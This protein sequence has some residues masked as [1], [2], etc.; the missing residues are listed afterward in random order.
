MALTALFEK[1]ERHPEETGSVYTLAENLFPRGGGRSLL[2]EALLK[3]MSSRS[4]DSKAE[5]V[6]KLINTILCCSGLKDLEWL[7]PLLLEYE[8]HD[9]CEV[10]TVVLNYINMESK[11]FLCKPGDSWA[12]ESDDE[13]EEAEAEGEETESSSATAEE[14]EDSNAVKCRGCNKGFPNKT[15]L[16]KNHL[17]DGVDGPTCPD[18]NRPEEETEEQVS[19][20]AAFPLEINPESSSGFDLAAPFCTFIHYVTTGK[21]LDLNPKKVILPL[22]KVARYFQLICDGRESCFDLMI[23]VL[24]DLPHYEVVRVISPRRQTP[25]A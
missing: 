16:L 10:V 24:T 20:A 6:L 15:V 11:R 5:E 8:N 2:C 7:G 9:H 14:A 23:A 3:I 18:D 21:A 17:V 12:V 1:T 4:F 19:A 25:T 22:D 13:E